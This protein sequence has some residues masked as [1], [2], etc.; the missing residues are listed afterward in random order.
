MMILIMTMKKIKLFMN[1][2]NKVSKEW[3]DILVPDILLITVF[4]G[5][6]I[7]MFINV[8]FTWTAIISLLMSSIYIFL[9]ISILRQKK[10]VILKN[11]SFLLQNVWAILDVLVWIM[12]IVNIYSYSGWKNMAIYISTLVVVVSYISLQIYLYVNKKLVFRNK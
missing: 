7:K 4:I 6:S 8:N 3:N 9:I 1:Q 11:V 5:K 2:Y 12:S 10:Y